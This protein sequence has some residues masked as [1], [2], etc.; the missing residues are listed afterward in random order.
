M[1]I[2][3]S[4]Y[5]SP[6]DNQPSFKVNQ[7]QTPNS[8][9]S[10][11]GNE[12]SNAPESSS[13]QRTDNAQQQQEVREQQQEERIIRELKARDVEVR[14]HEQAHANVGGSLAGAP[15]YSYTRGPDGVLYATSGEV[16]I[17]LSTEPGDPEAT[18]AKMEQVIRAALA[19]AE[20]SGQDRR[21]AAQAAAIA[22]DARSELNQVEESPTDNTN[23]SEDS[24]TSDDQAT[25]NNTTSITSNVTV[26]SSRNLSQRI[27]ETGAT[28][29]TPSAL[30]TLFNQIA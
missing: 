16:P 29:D 12:S 18:I 8:D 21:V 7:Q 3:T 23:S 11:T 22:A 13:S 1:I 19:P 2:N 28:K 27:D 15:S 10:V 9:E 17:D 25:T 26:L 14:A 24:P 20:P 5:H 6:F 30:G 4:L